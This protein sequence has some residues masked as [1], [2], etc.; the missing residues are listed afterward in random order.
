MDALICFGPF[1]LIKDIMCCAGPTAV[2]TSQRHR[3]MCAVPVLVI[4]VH[5]CVSAQG[6]W[7]GDRDGRLHQT[8]DSTSGLQFQELLYWDGDK[9]AGE[10]STG[11]LVLTAC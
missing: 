2:K 11:L 1:C 8:R 6:S 9:P 10:R 7:R 4:Q 3:S 5:A